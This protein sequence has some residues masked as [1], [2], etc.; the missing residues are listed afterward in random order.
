MSTRFAK[1]PDA[2]FLAHVKTITDECTAH[3][4]AWEIDSDRL[5]EMNEFEEGPW[6]ADLTEVIG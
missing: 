2:P 5:L 4:T 1:L 6:C 3:S